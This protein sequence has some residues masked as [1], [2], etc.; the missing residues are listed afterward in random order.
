MRMKMT[1]SGRAMTQGTKNET[2]DNPVIATHSVSWRNTW[3][4]RW[5]SLKAGTLGAIVA[6]LMFGILVQLNSVASAQ[7][8]GLTGLP[9]WENGVLLIADGAIA[10][11]SGFL[12]AVTYRYIM[13]QDQNPHLK[14]GAVGAFGLVRGLALVE[15]GLQTQASPLVLVALVVESFLLFGGVRFVLDWAIAQ[16]W[17]KPFVS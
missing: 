16:G 15:L 8:G 6:A 5:Q 1:V 14:S 17:I 11:L 4:E 13:R 7:M 3:A 2:V 10:K 9:T 12:F